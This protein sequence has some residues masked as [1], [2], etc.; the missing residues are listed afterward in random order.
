MNLKNYTNKISNK[1][2]DF[3]FILNAK[4]IANLIKELLGSHKL[5]IVDIGAGNRY[6]KTILNFD[7]AAKIVMIDPHKSLEWSVNNLKNKLKNKKEV[8]SYRVAIGRKT[9]TKELYL[10][11][12]PTGSTLVN[13]HKIAKNKK[14]MI[15]MNYFSTNKLSIKVYTFYDFLKKFSLPKPDIV[16]IDVEGLEIQVIESIL[17]CCK[18][19]LIELET[20]INSSI[21][22]DTFTTIHKILSKANYQLK[23]AYPAY[24]AYANSGNSFKAFLSGNYYYPINRSP[25]RQMDC[26]YVLKTNDTKK[27]L[28]ALIGWGLIFEA[29]DLYN[30]IFKKITPKLRKVI[31]NFLSI[32]KN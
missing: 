14:I 28:A 29:A 23:A 1:I 16:K 4:K 26:I 24:D 21:Y 30:K 15:D 17:K 6:L 3:K 27:K 18:P 5:S 22:G 11:K 32:C 25:L 20:N 10:S 12:R 9:Q 7:G 13:V 19:L 8:F 2:L 31:D